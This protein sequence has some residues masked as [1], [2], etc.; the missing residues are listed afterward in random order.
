VAWS[1]DLAM[2]YRGM[3]RTQLDT[4]YNNAAAVPQRDTIVA[5][6]TARSARVRRERPRAS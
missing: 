4:A 1:G 2:L 6:W 3:D 5:G